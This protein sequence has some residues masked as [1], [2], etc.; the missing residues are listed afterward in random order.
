MEGNAG[1]Q[2]STLQIEVEVDVDR[3][4][5]FIDV[6]DFCFNFGRLFPGEEIVSEFTE[7]EKKIILWHLLVADVLKETFAEV[8]RKNLIFECDE[9]GIEEVVQLKVLQEYSKKMENL[10]NQSL[11]ERLAKFEKPILFRENLQI[12]TSLKGVEDLLPDLTYQNLFFHRW[13]LGLLGRAERGGTYPS[14]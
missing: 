5:G 14:C 12:A 8:S 13:I 11:L 10:F 9:E 2:E 3:E 1:L 7:F 4:L 6:S